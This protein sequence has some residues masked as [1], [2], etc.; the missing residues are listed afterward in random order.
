MVLKEKM[1]SKVFLSFLFETSP[2]EVF[3]YKGFQQMCSKFTV[4]L[5]RGNFSLETHLNCRVMLLTGALFFRLFSGSQYVS[6]S[7]PN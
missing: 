2:K 7:K 1:S 6:T 3:Y 4:E 5:P